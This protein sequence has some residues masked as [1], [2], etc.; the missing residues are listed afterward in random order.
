MYYKLGIFSEEEYRDNVSYST[1]KLKEVGERLNPVNAI[2]GIVD[3]LKNTFSLENMSKFADKDTSY[4][5]KVAYAKEA[6]KTAITIYGGYK[7]TTGVFEYIIKSN[8]SVNHKIFVP[9]K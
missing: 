8:G 7:G 2:K 1:K 5:D 9:N 3:N 4:K 6:A